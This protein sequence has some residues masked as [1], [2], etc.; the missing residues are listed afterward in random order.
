MSIEFSRRDA[1]DW[2]FFR[3]WRMEDGWLSKEQAGRALEV[4]HDRLAISMRKIVIS[5]L[6]PTQGVFSE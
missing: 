4:F 1:L 6:Y 2:I 3:R 5:K